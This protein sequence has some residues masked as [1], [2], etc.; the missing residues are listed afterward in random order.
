MFAWTTFGKVKFKEDIYDHDIYIDTEMNA[1]PRPGLAQEKFGTGHT[2]CAE[3]LEQLLT[4]ECEALVIGTGQSGCAQLTR[5]AKELIA[6]RQLELHI[7]ESPKAIKD[8]NEI[9]I[10]RKTVAL[11]HVTC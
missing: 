3:E 9:C 11:I 4:P 1:H 10:T 8:Y 2:I 6:A 5:D 7:A